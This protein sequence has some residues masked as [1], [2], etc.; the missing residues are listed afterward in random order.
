[1]LKP[2]LIFKTY[3]LVAALVFSLSAAGQVN[4]DYQTRNS[5]NWNANTTWQ[6][7]SG[8][9]WVDCMAGDYPGSAPGTGT[10]NI[11]GSRTVTVTADVPNTIAS[12][13]IEGES[14]FNIVQFSGAYVLNVA[15]TI[16]INPPSAAANNY[17][18]L[19]LNSGIVTCSSLTSSNSNNP[20]RKCRVVISSGTLSVNGNITMGNDAGRNDLTFS[21]AGTLNVTGNL[22]TGQLAGSDNS[23]INVGGAFTPSAF[24][25]GTS[26]VNYNGGNQNI[27]A[28]VYF[29][30]H[31][32]NSGVKILP[33]IDITVNGELNVSNSTL[34]FTASQ[35]RSLSVAGN[36]SGNGTIN[37]SAGNLTHTLNLSGAFNTIGTLT[38]G[39]SASTVNYNREGDQTVFASPSYRNLTISGSGNKTLQ[40]DAAAGATFTLAGGT[41]SVGANTLSL[42][43]PPIAGMPDN[44]VTDQSS[45]L[46]FGGSSAGVFIPGSVTELDNL[47]IDNPSGVTL[48]GSVT[49]GNALSM[50]RGNIITGDGTIY[51]TN[52]ASGSLSYSEGTITGRFIR[53]IGSTGVSYLFPVGTTSGHNPLTI[54]FNDLTGGEL[55]VQFLPD[56]IGF[57][58]LPL[59][60]SGTEIFDRHT[61][62]Y[63]DLTA[64]GSLA[65]SSYDIIL[66]YYGFPGVDAL[67]RIL[68]RTG[69]G[70]LTLDGTHGTVSSPEI[71][72][73]GMSGISTSST[74][75][76][77]GKPNPRFVEQPSDHTGCNAIFTVLVSGKEPLTY[78]W[79][80]DRGEGFADLADDE[81]YS[82]AN[83]NT[84]TV[85]G[86]TTVMNGWQYRCLVTDVLGYSALSTSATLVIPEVTLGYKYSMDIALNPASGSSDLTD[87]PA[88]ISFENPLLSS[89]E[90]GGHVASLNGFDVIFTDHEGSKLD[91]QLEYYNPLTGRYVA[92]VRIPVL[93][94]TSA[95]TIKMLYGNPA[96][97]SNPSVNSVWI[98]SYKG[99]WHLNDDDYSDATSNSNDGTANTTIIV[100]GKI[101]GGKAFN[102]V[103]SYIQVPVNGFVP[104][105]NNQTISIW[106]NYAAPPAENRNLISFQNAPEGSAIHLGFREGNVAAWK[107]NGEVLVNGGPSP[108]ANAWHYYV[109]TFDG[110][111]SRLY[112][113]GTEVNS[114]VVAPQT[115]MPAEGNI[116]RYNDGEYIAAS[117]DEPR[118]S[119]SPKSAGWILT[120][121]NN[122]ND[123]GNFISLGSEELATGLPSAGVCSAPFSLDQGFP[124]GGVYS[125]PGVSG[126]DFDPSLAGVG[127]HLIT[128]IYTDPDGCSYSAS[129]NITVTPEPSAP[130]APDKECCISGIVDLEAAGISLKWYYDQGLT[131]LAGTGNPFATG[132]T[133]AGTYT[134]Y[135]TQTINGCESSASS[136]SLKIISGVTIVSQPASLTICDGNDVDFEVIATG[137]GLT[138]QWQEDGE[139]ISDGG[140]YNGVETARLILTNPGPEKEGKLY[141]CL[142][143]TTCGPSPATSDAAFFTIT[144]NNVW[145]GSVSSDWNDPGNWSCGYVP[146]PESIVM[147]PDVPNK[148]LLSTGSQAYVNDLTVESGS[149]LIINGN[150]ISI[151]GT[152][153]IN[154]TFNSSEGTVEMNG[155]AAQVIGSGI[156]TGNTIKDLI[157]NNPAGVTLTG[158]LSISGI[159]SVPGGTL[160]SDDNL[161]LLST[162]LQTA[163][164]D[165]SGSGTVTGDV[166]MQRYLPSGFGYKY[167]SSPFQS[168]TVGE[169]SDDMDLTAP[170]TTFY[171]YDENRNVGGNPASG[172]V[173]Y[174]IPSD[175]LQPLAG[176]AVNFGSS[177]D[178]GT[179][180]VKGV[181]NNGPL[182]ATLYN[183]NNPYTLGF[184]LVGNPYPSP[185]DWD[186]ASGW[187]K[188][189]INDAIYLFRAS[190][191]DEYGGTYSTYVNGIPSDGLVTGIIPSM[192]GFFIHVSDGDYPVSATLGLDN[193]VRRTDMAQS[194]FKSDNKS[195]KPLIRLN[196]RYSDDPESS[197][198]FVIYFDEK[199]TAGF[200]SKLDALK[201]MNTDLNVANLYSVISEGKKLSINA[202]PLISDDKCVVPLGL[203]TFRDGFVT[204]SISY[205]EESLTGIEVSLTDMATA[206]EEDLLSGSG[207]RIQLSSGEYNNRFYLNLASVS[208]EV[209]AVITGNPFFSVYNHN[210]ILRAEFHMPP[211]ESGLLIV[212]DLTG[213]ILLSRRIY[214]S[215]YQEFSHNYRSGVYIAT[216]I[217]GNRKDSR[218]IVILGP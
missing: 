179:V 124:S 80:E 96:V 35:P 75:L 72:R 79:Q 148:P 81:T 128:Y 29:S 63:W 196:A 191:T 104:N 30:L 61:T 131:E 182:S 111:T 135:V 73:T 82:G 162:P 215:G 137:Y 173:D 89:S 129:K 78:Q 94:S 37:M 15:G 177:A 83:S 146:G 93:S 216:F 97:S 108:S 188:S 150:I 2:N 171:R 199:A 187:T 76:A 153:T 197:D 86:A 77:I 194:F 4:G 204:F 25:A 102:G 21:G 159:L 14:G 155:S 180:D 91:H 112:I 50:I 49:V 98:S 99:V 105:D 7:R 189:N 20:N 172:W 217:T 47:T 6:V 140:I 5:G 109:Y 167:F 181:V 67:A 27:G 88:L 65:S 149:S 166:T 51:L 66:N 122:Q 192:Q 120:E 19:F 56:D 213:R 119:M 203:R 54:T 210:G 32:T 151:A 143:Y 147:I 18:G 116:G 107:W 117:L 115:A 174:K 38:T 24:T 130:L 144:S 190:T 185:I 169:F 95:T 156:F 168:A 26:T 43:G 145:S 178:P 113:D 68:K 127:T 175:V 152:I 218:K 44:L 183:N 106:A 208:T 28:H 195:T 125:G 64:A 10:V 40:G 186:A 163:L 12:L 165:G 123:P 121:F 11:T 161:T 45:G 211:G 41:F 134:Y 184:N 92:W 207:Y 13:E 17:N 3:S 90:N 114:S 9:A 198:P 164:I 84:L 59:D 57:N 22:T 74:G 201:L 70:E 139:N 103:S 55:A 132:E 23:I 48:N 58:G 202:L 69:S 157:I 209:P 176:Y 141:T 214:D 200:D 170:F 142:I 60:D 33:N 205:I 110:T 154:G 8:G 212:H 158:P 206:T 100:D 87:F 160:A 36:L 85:A 138:Y 39:T 31:A 42:N 1:M 193:S 34:A 136:V 62:G 46:S 71:T 52:S 133:V 101:A 53:G 126:T 118:F 16:A